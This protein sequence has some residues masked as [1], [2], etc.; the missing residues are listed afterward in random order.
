MSIPITCMPPPLDFVGGVLYGG[1]SETSMQAVIWDS[2]KRLAKLYDSEHALAIAEYAQ[3]A[4]RSAKIAAF[5]AL[6]NYDAPLK[7]NLR[8]LGERRA[9]PF[10][11]ALRK[12]CIKTWLENDTCTRLDLI[13]ALRTEYRNA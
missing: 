8:D 3:S 13:E 6:L 11:T 7:E 2:A 10:Y 1:V 5:F 4:E 9:G 12:R